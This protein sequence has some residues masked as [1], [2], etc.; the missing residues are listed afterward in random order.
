MMWILLLGAAPRVATAWQATWMGG[1]AAVLNSMMWILGAVLPWTATAWQANWMGGNAAVLGGSTLLDLSLPGTHDALTYDLSTTV[2]EAGIDDHPALAAVLHAASAAGVVPEAV[3]AFVRGQAQTQA[4]NM[5]AQLDAGVRFVD[6]RVMHTSGDWYG[7]H[8]LQ[9]RR[10]AA[11]YLSELRAWV[12]AHPTEVVAIWLSRHGSTSA[13]GD[14]QFP[15]VDVA[16]KRAL[17][18]SVLRIFDGVLVDVGGRDPLNATT[19]A[20]LVASNA[21][22]VV[23]ASDHEELT[24][25]S[26]FAV[27]ARARLENPLPFSPVDAKDLARD[28][29]VFAS[30]RGAVAAAKRRDAFLLYSMANAPPDAA[31]EGAFRGAFEAGAGVADCAAAYHVPNATAWCP[32]TLL[33]VGQLA[34]FYGQTAV[35]AA[36]ADGRGFP[37]A[38]YV[39]AYDARG[40]LRTGTR[41]LSRD[42]DD[43]PIC[44]VFAWTGCASAHPGCDG[45]YS[46][47]AATA[48]WGAHDSDGASRAA[49][50]LPRRDRF[51][52][53]RDAD[54]DRARDAYPFVATVVAYNVRTACAG[55]AGNPACAGLLAAAEARRGADPRRVWEDPATAR[56]ARCPPQ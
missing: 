18:A 41:V 44:D 39:D 29:A 34:N 50:A 5:S 2:S 25:N 36:Y 10:P 13:V 11:A 35:E 42:G 38:F 55:D 26:T 47:G 48:H 49:C 20:E 52:C 21:R 12:D 37:H 8:L 56:L 46:P 22:V 54:G 14:D 43:A 23:F 16:A 4:L 30:T 15:G 17:W 53:C 9:T 45:A 1:N 32:R 6:F 51:Q 27:D 24:G 28:A 3:G 31:I 19:L 33:D 7:L 40:G